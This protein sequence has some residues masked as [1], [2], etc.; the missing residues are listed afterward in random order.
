MKVY[1]VGKMSE[2][3]GSA[4]YYGRLLEE[5][6]QRHELPPA[7]GIEFEGV[8]VATHR[9]VHGSESFL[10][11]LFHTD[12]GKW[13]A[14]HL[15]VAKWNDSYATEEIASVHETREGAEKWLLTAPSDE[16]GRYVSEEAL[17][18]TRA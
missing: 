1:H 18:R 3:Q 9:N 4:H 14:H 10:S 16:Y 7:V 17:G 2:S 11:E 8:R 13:I 12:G 6:P 15:V 5:G